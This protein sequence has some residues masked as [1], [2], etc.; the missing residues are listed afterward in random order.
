MLL[1]ELDSRHA[2]LSR[3]ATRVLLTRA[4]H[5]FGEAQYARLATISVVTLYGTTCWTF[6]IHPMSPSSSG[7]S[8]NR[9]AITASR[10]QS[11]L[12]HLLIAHCS[13]EGGTQDG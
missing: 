7:S 10:S 12:G 8:S 9:S 3:P 5:L 4:V 2:T 1:A 11:G 6:S 13:T